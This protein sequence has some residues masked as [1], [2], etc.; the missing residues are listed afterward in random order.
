M[1]SR[2]GKQV[3]ISIFADLWSGGLVI[4]NPEALLEAHLMFLRVRINLLPRESGGLNS[5]LEWSRVRRYRNLST[6]SSESSGKVFLNEPT[7]Q[8]F[9]HPNSLKRI[10]H[11]RN[12]TYTSSFSGDYV[13]SN[14]SIQEIGAKILFY[15]SS[16]KFRLPSELARCGIPIFSGIFGRHFTPICCHILRSLWSNFV[17]WLWVSVFFIFL[18][19]ETDSLTTFHAS[20]WGLLSFTRWLT[21]LSSRKIRYPSKIT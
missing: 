7:N 5:F 15:L 12:R 6:S 10:M 20:K 2:V 17:W 18:L 16:L 13:N 14:P 19:M 21:I 9:I 4:S 8:S 1:K 11:G 3:S